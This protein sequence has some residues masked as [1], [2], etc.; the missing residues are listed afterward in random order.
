MILRVN[1]VYF[2]NVV[3]EPKMDA[4]QAHDGLKKLSLALALA[5]DGKKPSAAEFA[6]FGFDTIVLSDASKALYEES[7]ELRINVNSTDHEGQTFINLI[8]AVARPEDSSWRV[9]GVPIPGTTYMDWGSVQN[10]RTAR[11]KSAKLMTDLAAGPLKGRELRCR[12]ESVDMKGCRQGLE[13]LQHALTGNRSLKDWRLIEI[14][15]LHLGS[16]DLDTT[17]KTVVLSYDSSIPVMQ[18]AL[19]E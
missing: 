11:E 18:E 15:N 14:S 19:S 3:V 6:K 13:S 16:V 17:A 12:F 1:K 7:G 4:Y 9:A 10:F 2:A 5:Y 8:Q